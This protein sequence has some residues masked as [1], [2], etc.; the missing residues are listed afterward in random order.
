MR[1]YAALRD[2]STVGARLLFP[3]AHPILGFVPEGLY[4]DT[5][6]KRMRARPTRIVRE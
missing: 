2:S 5:I 3:F 4:G 6:D 1:E